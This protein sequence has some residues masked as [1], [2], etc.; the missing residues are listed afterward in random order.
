MRLLSRWPYDKSRYY[1]LRAAEF[2]DITHRAAQFIYLNRTCWNGLYRVNR[3]GQ[4]NVPFGRFTN[5]TINN[6][7][8]L[9][10]A[11]RAL[12]HAHLAAEDFES[13]TESAGRGDFVYLDPPYSI[14]HEHNGF[15]RYNEHLFSWQDQLRL[16]RCATRLARKGVQVVISN[17]YHPTLLGLYPHFRH[18]VVTR[19]SMLAGDPTKRGAAREVILSSLPLPRLGSLTKRVPS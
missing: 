3:Q 16:A 1:K 15:L 2:H 9:A 8:A 10:A 5:P 4:F 18:V 19:P 12:N 6:K 7:T 13:A 17:A 11:S 14:A